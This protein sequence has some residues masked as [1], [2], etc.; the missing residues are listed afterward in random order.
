M[1]AAEAA[2]VV[3]V[4]VLEAAPEEVAAEG[5]RCGH[6]PS[7]AFSYFWPQLPAGSKRSVS[8]AAAAVAAVPVAAVPVAGESTRSASRTAATHTS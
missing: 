1:L 3:T 2:V 8:L 7:P 4:T 6:C 5:V